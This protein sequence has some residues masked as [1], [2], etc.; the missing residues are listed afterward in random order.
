MEKYYTFADV[1]DNM[2]PQEQQERENISKQ[3]DFLR[4]EMERMR[5]ELHREN[6]KLAR[7]NESPEWY[8]EAQ[9]DRLNALY[10]E[11]QST[12]L[13]ILRTTQDNLPWQ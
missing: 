5:V 3:L 8:F 9:K 13:I 1:N 6:Q 10:K 2:T 12:P 7:L 11:W 4:S